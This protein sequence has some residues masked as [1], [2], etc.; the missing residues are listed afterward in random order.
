MLGNYGLAGLSSWTVFMLLPAWL[1]MRRFPVSQWATPAIGPLAAIATLDA[2]YMID[3]LS[4][5]FFNP[6]YLVGSGGLICTL[7]SRTH[8]GGAAP[9]PTKPVAFSRPPSEERLATQYMELARALK[10]QG[11]TVQAKAAWAHALDS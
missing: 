6:I 5:G 10:H 4:N 11:Q 3:C 1:F 2:L 7:P 8:D 9:D